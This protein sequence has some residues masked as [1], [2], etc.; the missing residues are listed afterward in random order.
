VRA[1]S[2][3]LFAPSLPATE[4]VAELLVRDT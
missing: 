4:R 1:G 2:T 3:T